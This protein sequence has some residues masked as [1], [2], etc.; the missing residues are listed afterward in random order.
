MKKQLMVITVILLIGIS[1]WL[2]YDNKSAE[3]TN[4]NTKGVQ[5]G[6]EE[7]SNTISFGLLD[8][9]DKVVN[10]GS[11]LEPKENKLEYTFSLSNF[12]E[13]ERDYALIVLDNFKQIPFTVQGKKF[14][15]YPFNAKANKTVE[16][17]TS[18][19]VKKDTSEI[20]YL[21]IKKP[22]Y[23]TE[24][25]DIPKMHSLQEILP[26]RFQVKNNSQKQKT[27]T[28]T[29]EEMFNEGPNDTI[30]ISKQKEELTILPTERSGEDIYISVGNINEEKEN[31]NIIALSNWK[32]V[33]F[34]NNELVGN[35][36]VNPGER[37]VFKFKLPFVKAD[38]NFQVIALPRPYEVSE[39]DYE[40]TRAEGSMRA[41][42]K[43]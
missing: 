10:N 17:K 37:K 3:K 39:K 1:G 4:G 33:P 34:E 19:S 18:I 43:P 35:V 36:L 5:P 27:A 14:N 41:V 21:V 25:L 22:N 11:I 15:V 26:L 23:F 13:V 6:F 32:Q 9:N 31:Y 42:I 24:K 8:E 38:S 12:I 28:F 2:L 30:F 40:S 7:S 20:D 29:P 16:F